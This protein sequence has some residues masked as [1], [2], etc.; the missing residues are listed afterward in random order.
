MKIEILTAYIEGELTD[1]VNA[2]LVDREIVD[3]QFQVAVNGLKTLYAAMILYYEE[4]A[5]E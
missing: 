5:T 4:D 2:F 3:I 1:K